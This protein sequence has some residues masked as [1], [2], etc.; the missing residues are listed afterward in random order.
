MRLLV[1]LEASVP[2]GRRSRSSREARRPVRSRPRTMA[3][4][5]A[6][7]ERMES[8]KSALLAGMSGLAVLG[9]QAQVSPM[10]FAHPFEPV[11]VTATRSVTDPLPTLRDAVVV[12]RDELEAAG[13][14]TL[15]E[16]LQRYAG[17]EIRA[18]GGPG[19]P[20]G[21]FL[22]GAGSAQT[23]VLVEGLRVASPPAGTTAIEPIPLEMIERIEVVKGPLSSL[24]GS[25]AI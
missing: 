2:P 10:P 3:C 5:D 21:L 12:T 4:G 6:G 22:R 8:M 7:R 24:Y 23:L 11:V 25:D 17:V 9:A 1:P 14:V 13:P 20:A 18:T 15:A 19:Q 16:A